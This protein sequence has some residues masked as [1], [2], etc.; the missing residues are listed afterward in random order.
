MPHHIF[1]KQQRYPRIRTFEID[2]ETWFSASDIIRNLGYKKPKKAIKKYCNSKKLINETDARKLIEK[3]KNSSD[4]IF[5]Y[6]QFERL[7][8]KR[9]KMSKKLKL[10]FRFLL[11]NFFML[12]M[13]W[14]F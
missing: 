1:K 2:N 12:K 5:S 10:I 8:G 13:F 9:R 4:I 14:I 6:W 7:K 11:K 3:S